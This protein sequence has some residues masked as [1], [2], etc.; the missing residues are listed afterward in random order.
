MYPKDLEI[1]NLNVLLFSPDFPIP[2]CP[3]TMIFKVLGRECKP[4]LARDDIGEVTFIFHI[5][6][7]NK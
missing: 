1:F 4:S 2:P 7:K 6:K 5:C 3:S